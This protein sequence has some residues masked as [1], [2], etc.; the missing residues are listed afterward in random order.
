MVAGLQTGVQQ[1][2]C[3]HREHDGAGGAAELRLLGH[4]ALP[5]QGA[6]PQPEDGQSAAGAGAH[7]VSSQDYYFNQNT[8]IKPFILILGIRSV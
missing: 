2:L 5:R 4:L 3:Q 1:D 6:G 7:Q 8:L